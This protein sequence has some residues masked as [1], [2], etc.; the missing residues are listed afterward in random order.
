ML[1]GP[2]V[3]PLLW[4][5]S[6]E[7]GRQLRGRPR[8]L[9][10]VQNDEVR[11]KLALVLLQER[12]VNKTKPLEILG[13]APVGDFT[14]L[15]ATAHSLLQRLKISGLWFGWVCVESLL[16]KDFQK[17]VLLHSCGLATDNGAVSKVNDDIVVVLLLVVLLYKEV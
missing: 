6:L 2:N 4:G 5:G 17:T 7:R 8:H 1:R 12:D 11:P 16:I 15:Y 14:L 3:L 10:E 13:N 9:M